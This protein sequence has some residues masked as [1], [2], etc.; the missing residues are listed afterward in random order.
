MMT[1]WGRI[2]S[3]GRHP[4]IVQLHADLLK[5]RREDEAIS[6]K[7]PRSVDGAVLGES[8]F[9]LRYLSPN[10]D[11][12]L[13]VVNLGTGVDLPHLPEPLIAPPTGHRW[14]VK[15]SSE[16]PVYGGSGSSAP[17]RF[18]AWHVTGECTQLLVPV[19]AD[20]PVKPDPPKDGNTR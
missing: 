20:G 3:Q 12:R 11:D 8:C 14:E 7:S 10:Q 4:E 6:G 18:G 2:R 15:W 13:I 17:G 19:H 16:L 1:S 9:V 5:L